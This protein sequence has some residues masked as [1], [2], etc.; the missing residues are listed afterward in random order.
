MPLIDSD[1]LLTFDAYAK[2]YP[3]RKGGLG[4]RSSYVYQL[5]TNKKLPANVQHLIICGLNFVYVPEGHPLT[6]PG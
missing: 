4:V 5:V 2:V 3:N 1:R 6:P